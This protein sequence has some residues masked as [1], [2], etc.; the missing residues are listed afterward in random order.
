M[1]RLIA[2]TCF[3]ST[4]SVTWVTGGDGGGKEKPDGKVYKS[5]VELLADMPKDNYPRA[6]GAFAPER[7]AANVWLN[8]NLIGRQIEWKAVVKDVIV[9]ERG[10]HWLVNLQPDT[11][12]FGG[13]DIM[14]WDKAVALGEEKWQVGI[15]YYAF[16]AGGPTRLAF[17]PV[18]ADTV[19]HL[20]KWKDKEVTLR[21]TI[22]GAAVMDKSPALIL[23][24]DSPTIDGYRPPIIK[25]K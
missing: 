7:K 10:E 22:T 16:G 12:N 9:V 18:A 2:L 20:R 13:V 21:A 5:P 23:Q 15:Y 1:G 11:M 19:K 3:I 25:G 17:Y 14:P 6:G 24:V 8:K 4:I